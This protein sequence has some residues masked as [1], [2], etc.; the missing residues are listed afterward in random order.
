MKRVTGLMLI[1]LLGVLVSTTTHAQE[2]VAPAID[3]AKMTQI[4]R[5]ATAANLKEIM[6]D[7]FTEAMEESMTESASEDGG[8]PDDFGQAFVEAFTERFNPDDFLRQV[9]APVLDEHFTLSE[10][11][12]VADFVESDLG[13]KLIQSKLT[14]EEADMEKMLA[15]GEIS[16]ED[17]AKLMQL[18]IRL[19]KKKA[20]LEDGTLAAEIEERAR[21]FGEALAME[22]ISDMMEDYMEDAMEESETEVA[23]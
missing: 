13:Q 21:V 12:L 20:L 7:K 11:T 19:G 22:I 8:L 5:I 4:E 10:L 6:V 1:L 16:E 15:S 3:A 9:V 17:G 23:E 18:V 14:N 2:G